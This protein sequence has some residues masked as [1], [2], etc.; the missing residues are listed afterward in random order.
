M[1]YIILALSLLATS[2]FAQT[3][4]PS[5]VKS[6]IPAGWTIKDVV[7]GQLNNDT[8]ED[9]ILVLENKKI[10]DVPRK[11]MIFLGE[12]NGYQLSG[13]SDTAVFCEKCG[14]IY[15]D[16]YNGIQV[17]KKKVTINNYGGS[18]WRWSDDFTFAYSRIDKQWQLV[19]VE[20]SSYHNSNPDK[21]KRTIKLPKNFGKI[22]LEN[23]DPEKF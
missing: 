13:T 7:T 23:F 18:A 17:E 2:S 6:Q 3:N 4:I 9:L 1:K 20:K 21:E 5:S 19:M 14:G 11:I 10:E 12:D 15:G 8:K 16:P 22:S